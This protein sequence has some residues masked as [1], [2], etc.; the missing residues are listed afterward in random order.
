MRFLS[1]RWKIAASVV[2]AILALM[3]FTGRL[4][5]LLYPVD[6]NLHDCGKNGYGA[7]FCGSDLTAYQNRIQGV[8]QQVQQ[9]EQTI[10]QQECQAD[11]HLP[12]CTSP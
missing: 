7:V 4:D 3:Y 2:V 9:T 10:T 5:Y 6:L 11:P 1:N 8:Q 12:F